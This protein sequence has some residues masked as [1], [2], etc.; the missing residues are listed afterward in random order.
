M[1]RPPI[2]SCAAVLA[3]WSCSA[4][5]RGARPRANSSRSGSGTSSSLSFSWLSCCSSTFPMPPIPPTATPGSCSG[6]SAAE[7]CAAHAGAGAR[8]AGL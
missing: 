6:Q 4:A 8:R 7:R 1:G 3:A 5:A 2:S